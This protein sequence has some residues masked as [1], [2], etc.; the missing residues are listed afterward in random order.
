MSQ[1]NDGAEPRDRDPWAPPESSAA[2]DAAQ[3]V[4]LTK[5]P[6]GA[7]AP[8][9]PE[10][11]AGAGAPP[12]HSMPTMTSVP[13]DGAAPPPPTA[14]GGPTQPPSYGYPGAGAAGGPAGFAQPNPGPGG[15]NPGAQAY[16]AFTPGAANPGY[17]GYPGYQAYPQGGWQLPREPQNGM[18][19]AAMVLGICSLATFYIYGIFGFVLGVIAVILGVIGRRRAGRGEANNPGQALAGI[20]TGAIGIV[21]GAAFL[22]FLI[23]LVSTDFTDDSDQDTITEVTDDTYSLSLVLDQEP[24]APFQAT[25]G[26]R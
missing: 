19:I 10:A 17:P 22:A 13:G 8:S 20:I 11:P 4:G 14:P 9:G 1:P 2:R 12:V 18:G 16:G 21:L 5:E 7:A 26:S 24:I 6:A 23:W 15:P 3:R 25:A